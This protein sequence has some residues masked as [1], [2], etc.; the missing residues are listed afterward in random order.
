MGLI[1]VILLWWLA[2]EVQAY[3]SILKHLYCVPSEMKADLMELSAM[4][5]LWAS[6]GGLLGRRAESSGGHYSIALKVRS[7]RLIS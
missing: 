5:S 2:S 3:N 1:Q 4:R 7:F 6:T